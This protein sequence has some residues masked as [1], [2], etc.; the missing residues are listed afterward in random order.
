MWRNWHFPTQL[1]EMQNG[2][3]CFGNKSECSLNGERE[4][5]HDPAILHLVTNPRKWKHTPMQK[6]IKNVHSSITQRAKTQIFINWCKF[7][8][9]IQW[10]IIQHTEEMKYEF[11]LSIDTLQNHYVKGKKS[12]TTDQIAHDSIYMQCPEQANL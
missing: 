6:L 2:S 1:E 12:I 5:L 9:S 8:I 11:R 3:S 7:G 4:F 10:H